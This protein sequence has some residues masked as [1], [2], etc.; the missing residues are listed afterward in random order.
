MILEY[1]PDDFLNALLRSSIMQSRRNKDNKFRWIGAQNPYTLR[2]YYLIMGDYVKH[3][4]QFFYYTDSVKCCWYPLSLGK[5]NLCS[6][7]INKP[8]DSTDSYR[9]FTR[10]VT[11]P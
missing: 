3:P 7:S 11:T 4:T 5:M 2:Y 10:L 6:Y 9:W 1:L 8:M